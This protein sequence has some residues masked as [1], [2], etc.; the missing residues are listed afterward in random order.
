M[1]LIGGDDGVVPAAHR[2]FYH[3]DINDVFVV[4]P[5]SQLPHQA[6]LLSRHSLDTATGQH[7]SQVGLARATSPSLSH[8]RRRNNRYHF[9]GKKPHVK[10]PYA[11]VTPFPCDERSGVVGNSGH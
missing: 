5:S 10:S 6:G 1:R 7:A 3:G 2:A 8:Y 9:L 4:R 11:S